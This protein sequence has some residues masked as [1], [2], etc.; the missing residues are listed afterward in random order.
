MND[1]CKAKPK[2]EIP[3]MIPKF[4]VDALHLKSGDIYF[5]SVPKNSDAVNACISSPF[6]MILTII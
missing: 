4:T 3:Y 1:N 6:L 2:P 5:I